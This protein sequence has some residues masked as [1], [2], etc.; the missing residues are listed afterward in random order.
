MCIEHTRL[1]LYTTIAVIPASC[2]SLIQPLDVVVNA[3]FKQK[4]EQY[5]EHHYEAHLD[6]WVGNR[7]TVILLLIG[8]FL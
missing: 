8:V 7:Y 3:S 2:T 1:I 6:E 4:L 5:A